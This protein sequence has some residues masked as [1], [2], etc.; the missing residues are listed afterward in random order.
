MSEQSDRLSR[1]RNASNEL[2]R[3]H[4]AFTESIVRF[5]R[6]LQESKDAGDDRQ[7][8]IGAVIAGV[9]TD[10][11]RVAAFESIGDLLGKMAEG[12]EDSQTL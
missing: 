9:G 2:T 10:P 7:T 11:K 1:I 8:A 6:A 5:K 12:M 4:V 3:C